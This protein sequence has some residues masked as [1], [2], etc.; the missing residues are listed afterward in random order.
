M[1]HPTAF[2]LVIGSE[3][4]RLRKAKGVTQKQ[5][6]SRMNTVDSVISRYENGKDEVSLYRFYQICGFLGVRNPGTQLKKL[7]KELLQIMEDSR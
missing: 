1:L 2:K 3:I 4:K 6:A 5:L 7:E